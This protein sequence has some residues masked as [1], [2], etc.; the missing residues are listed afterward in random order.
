LVKNQIETL[1]FYHIIN[2]PARAESEPT[3]T[4]TQGRKEGWMIS[5]LEAIFYQV[6]VP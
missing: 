2:Q 3:P 4:N 1:V 6:P 5:G